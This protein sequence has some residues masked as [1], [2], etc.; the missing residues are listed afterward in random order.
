MKYYINL[1]VKALLIIIV[2]VIIGLSLL[3]LSFEIPVDKINNNISRSISVF[4]E[5]GTYPK[6]SKFGISGQLDN[7]TDSYMLLN[8]GYKGNENALEKAINVYRE[9]INDIGS[10][11]D[12]LIS[13]YSGE[14]A[15]CTISYSRYWHGYLIFLKPLLLF[16]SYGEIR[17]LNSI[18]VAGG[19]LLII[20]LLCK[21][22][23]KGYIVPYIAM[24]LLM[25]VFVITKSLQFS[26]VYHICT[27]AI[28]ILLWRLECLEAEQCRMP[29]FFLTIGCVTS[30]F[31]FLTYPLITLGIPMVIYLCI[32]EIDDRLLFKKTIISTSCW[33]LGY[34]GM[35]SGK[36]VIGTYLGNENIILNAINRI[37]IHSAIGEMAENKFSYVDLIKQ[38]WQMLDKEVVILS[39]AFILLL[40]VYILRGQIK[41][42][43]I[44]V[45]SFGFVGL[46]PFCW[47]R[48]AASH[49]WQ[50]YWFTY[51]EMIICIFSMM[52]LTIHIIKD[53][54]K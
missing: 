48:I 36:W 2:S 24:L 35:W 4:K 9:Y 49:S 14:E 28:I 11:T 45:M 33:T 22:N 26:S 47:Y 44:D 3:I 7:W 12:V 21:R 37:K 53:N 6:V 38:Q 41:G 32:S 34:V 17:I 25:N 27:I 15:E 1:S 40:G 20:I 51:R 23:L 31:D 39:V 19:V 52:C 29:L 16:L 5:E 54:K 46:L 10:P 50:H 42:K 18:L 43:I 13:L 30:Y 8:A